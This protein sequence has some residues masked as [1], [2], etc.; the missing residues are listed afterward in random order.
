[1]VKDFQ[2]DTIRSQFPLLHQRVNGSELIYL[3]NAATTQKPSAVIE[4]IDHYYR[5]INSNVHRGV[6]HLSVQ[7]TNASEEA[8]GLVQQLLNARKVEEIIFTSGTT[9]SINLVANSYGRR[10]LKEGDEVLIST[11]EHH[12]NIVPWQL[13]CEEKKATLKVI[14]IN[15]A[16]ELNL[17][18]YYA[19]LS[20]RTKLVA[21]NHVSNALGTLNSIKEMCSAAKKVG[22]VFLVDG[23]QAVAHLKVDVQDLDCDFYCF[24]GH[25]FYGPTGI[26]VLFGKEDILEEMPPFLGGG[27]MI[28]SVTFEKTSF[29]ELPY[30]FEAGTPAIAQMVGL[31][32][33]LRFWFSIDH[34]SL[35]Q[36]EKELLAYASDSLKEISELKIYGD[37]KNKLSVISFN[38]GNIHPFDLG[39][40]LD[41][42]GIA[43]RTGHH[44]T[45]PLMNRFGIP[46][47]VRASFAMYNS[48][49]EVNRLKKAI[50]KAVDLLS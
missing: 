15:D 23:A 35:F 49:S 14:P 47:T 21:V 34:Q 4:A 33:A 17:E 43:V 10:N 5:K 2:I 30:K 16:G 19:L 6:H 11:L 36:Y 26:G 24:S 31:A 9:E 27:E 40:L 28:K 39:T 38:V 7:A 18:D 42:M 8:R 44:C 29:N 1:M 25:K 48:F 50:E 46:G 13:I 45:E 20:E 37:A 22:A 41:Q 12:S 32:E 3:D